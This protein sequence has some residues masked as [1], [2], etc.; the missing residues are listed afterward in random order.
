[1]TKYKL[2]I[3]KYKQQGDVTWEYNALRN[4]KDSSGR[5]KNFT[6]D[7]SKSGFNLNLENPVDIECQPSYDGTV[8]LILN[9]D[10]NPPRIINSRWS[11]TENNTYKIINREQINQSNLYREEFL[12]RETRLFRNTNGVTKID[13]YNVSYFGKLKAGNYIFYMKYMDD[14]YNETDIVAQTGVISIFNGTIT[15]PNTVSGGF[16][17]EET[18]KSILL[19]LR[20]LDTS[21]TYF[22]LYVYRTS[23]DSNGLKL[24]QAY[25]IEKDYEITNTSDL[26]YINGHEDIVDISIEELN[27]QYN[28]VDSVKSQAQVQN[29][30]FFA[31]VSK[32]KDMDS[33]L[34][35]MSL[36]IKAEEVLSDESIGFINPE[37][38]KKKDGDDSWQVEYY[39]PLN[40]YY[41]LGYWPDEM[42]RFG[43]V[44]IYNDDHLSPVYNLRGCKFETEGGYC[45]INY[46]DD[47][48]DYTKRNDEKIPSS[49]DWINSKRYLN[50]KGVFKFSKRHNE[51]LNYNAKEI[52][53]LGIKFSIPRLMLNDLHKKNIKGFFIVR[54]PRIP[55][56]LCQGYSVGVDRA[57]F[58]PML[59]VPDEEDGHKYI[60]E[61][62]KNENGTLVTHAKSRLLETKNTQSSGLI[63]VDAYCNKQLQSMFDTS[64]FKVE[65]MFDQT[66]IDHDSKCRHYWPKSIGQS[67]GEQSVTSLIYIDP[68]IPQK[69]HQDKGFSTKAGMQEDLKY[70]ACFD[71]NDPTGENAK[72]VRGIFTAF[73]GSTKKLSDGYVYNVRIKNYEESF[74]KEYFEIRMSNNAPYYAV[75]ERYCITPKE[76][77]VDYSM[78]GDLAYNMPLTDFYPLDDDIALNTV[79]RGDC[80]TNTVTTRL[81][82]NF[83]SSSVPIND[84]I[85]DEQTWKSHFKG[86]RYTTDWNKINKADI[87]A[88]PI[89]S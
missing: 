46:G 60:V 65:R 39:S 17:D 44:Y 71:K 26:I 23:C 84:I 89:G 67:G 75:S 77:A 62:F 85:I 19:K 78:F 81:H 43:I 33:D 56:I 8:N 31:N 37:N 30:L 57:G 18:D 70:S 12:D 7:N 45:N 83:T 48:D 50:T 51:I 25:K 36:Y 5:I 54:Q 80:F 64:E 41:K 87:D 14:D 11:R 38:Y 61:S 2:L 52:R 59:R 27:I 3:K 88:V 13:L 55:S 66:S 6:I 22:K 53:P 21:F 69:I 16:M 4:L 76:D 40:I 63:C 24:D 47:Y 35:D 32:P 79:F 82:R 72:L 49:A 15:N 58:Y 74:L 1:M 10:I 9:D 29:M 34:Q 73:I 42:Y 28:I 20:D 68:E 86:I